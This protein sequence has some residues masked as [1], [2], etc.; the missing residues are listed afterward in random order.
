MSS[1]S[2]PMLQTPILWSK[3]PFDIKG[4]AQ[5]QPLS[6]PE[7]D[8]VGFGTGLTIILSRA[9]AGEVVAPF[10]ASLH[11]K[12]AGKLPGPLVGHTLWFP[13]TWILVSI[14]Q[15]RSTPLNPPGMKENL[16]ESRSWTE[17]SLLKDESIACGTKSQQDLKQKVHADLNLGQSAAERALATEPLYSI[18]L[19]PCCLG[20][21]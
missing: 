3:A 18:T 21:S 14:I 12:L 5:H 4:H 11:L 8:L 9:S 7:Q 2:T 10:Y 1:P 20:L 15:T 17:L 19:G 16:A 13:Q 6:G